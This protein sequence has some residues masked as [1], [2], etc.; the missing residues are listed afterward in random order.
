M[1]ETLKK[2]IEAEKKEKKIPS[3]VFLCVFGI[4][5]FAAFQF[6][7]TWL[8]ES[9]ERRLQ[10][11]VQSQDIANLITGEAYNKKAFSEELENLKKSYTKKRNI[12]EDMQEFMR[13]FA[14]IPDFH[15]DDVGLAMQGV[16][17][18]SG[19]KGKEEWAV[20]AKWAVMRQQSSVLQMENPL[21]WH[22]AG[23]QPALL[24]SSRNEKKAVFLEQEA[25]KVIIEAERG[26]IYNDNTKVILHENVR[27]MQQDNIVKGPVLNYDTEKQI[28]VFSEQA[29]FSSEELTGTAELLSWDMQE[30]KIYGKGGVYVEWMPANGE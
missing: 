13:Y 8:A 18:S 22:R 1:A 21:M 4:G 12:D 6:W 15:D 3:F 2:K 11:V 5:L 7:N 16:H 26:I 24:S 17:V 14:E 27:A 30:N 28:A 10:E 19:E 20:F 29:D 25:D 9:E 23:T